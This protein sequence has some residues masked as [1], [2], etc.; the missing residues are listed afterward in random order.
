VLIHRAAAFAGDELFAPAPELRD[1]I[2]DRIVEAPVE[3]TEFCR[4]DGRVLLDGQV[5][6]GL[7]EIPVVMNDLDHIDAVCEQFI[8]VLGRRLA[9][10][11]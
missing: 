9:D 7:A 6:Y 8:A 11:G 10:V 2:R 5:G 1:G 3:R 4:G